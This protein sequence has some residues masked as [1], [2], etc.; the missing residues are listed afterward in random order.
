MSMQSG[1]VNLYKFYSKKYLFLTKNRE[2]KFWCLDIERK[3]YYTEN[4]DK[5]I[6]LG[7]GCKIY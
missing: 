5:L 6:S 7:P 3:F 4:N 1:G 2:L